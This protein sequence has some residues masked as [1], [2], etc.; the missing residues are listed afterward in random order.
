[1]LPEWFKPHLC[2][3]CPRILPDSLAVAKFLHNVM[4]DLPSPSQGHLNP[5]EIPQHLKQI[6]GSLQQA[7][8]FWALAP[9]PKQ[10]FKNLGIKAVCG[11]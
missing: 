8:Q 4:C 11:F 2:S 7:F 6:I 10:F 9:T 1:M 5:K 3:L